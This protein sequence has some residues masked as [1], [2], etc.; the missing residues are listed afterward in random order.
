MNW[1]LWLKAQG[2]RVTGLEVNKQYVKV[3]FNSTAEYILLH[4]YGQELT[5]EE[6]LMAYVREW[7]PGFSMW[8]FTEKYE[9]CGFEMVIAPF[10]TGGMVDQNGFE[11]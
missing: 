8:Y 3:K 6:V 5:L 7:V 11:L 4:T 10:R 1:L 2:F 9:L